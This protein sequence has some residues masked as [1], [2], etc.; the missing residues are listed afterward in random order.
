M[1]FIKKSIL[2]T[3]WHSFDKKNGA[4]RPLGRR[5]NDFYQKVYRFFL[6]YLRLVTRLLRLLRFRFVCLR[7]P[8]ALEG[9]TL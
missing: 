4:S 8:P 9:L 6:L 1:I 2:K 7:L 5:R 3:I